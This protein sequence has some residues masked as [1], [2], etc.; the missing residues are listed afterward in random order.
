MAAKKGQ[1]FEREICKLLSIWW[2]SGIKDDIFWRTPGSGAKATNRAKKGLTT[3]DSYGDVMAMHV[4]GKPLTNKFVISIKRGYTTKKPGG[5]NLRCL[6]LTDL[7]DKPDNLKTN[8]LLV[9][10][11]QELE[12]DIRK[13]RRDKNGIIIARRD[14]RNA[15]IIMPRKIFTD[16][17]AKKPCIFPMYNSGCWL[18]YRNLDLQIM[19]LNDFFYWCNPKLLGAK[20][21][22]R[23][24]GERLNINYIKPG[25]FPSLLRDYHEQLK[26]AICIV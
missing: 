15:I 8:P 16:I 13:S 5:K 24:P 17:E 23:R 6:D 22:L 19:Q 21:F 12:A 2:T 1:N 3:H 11:W 20:T 18:Q 9:D 4:F 7:L 25:P 10:W 14:R 26:K